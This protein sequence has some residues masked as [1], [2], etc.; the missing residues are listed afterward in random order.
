MSEGSKEKWWPDA[1]LAGRAC[2]LSRVQPRDYRS[3][4]I[5]ADCRR[6]LNR[7]DGGGVAT[8]AA[9]GYATLSPR[10]PSEGRG[11]TASEKIYKERAGGGRL[12]VARRGALVTPAYP[13]RFLD[14]YHYRHYSYYY[15]HYYY[16]RCRRWWCI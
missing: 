6:R 9:H 14:H 10:C 3:K 2:R 5:D 1:R 8:P 13:L 7:A 11:Q 15:D 16:R 12:L 4:R